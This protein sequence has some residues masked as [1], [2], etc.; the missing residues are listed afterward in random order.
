MTPTQAGVLFIWTLGTNVSEILTK[1]H[2]FSFKKMHLKMSSANW[3]QFYLGLN[4]LKVWGFCLVYFLRGLWLWEDCHR[5]GKLYH[6]NSICKKPIYSY[7]VNL[8]FND[9]LFNPNTS[10]TCLTAWC[11]A[12]SMTIYWTPL[13]SVQAQVKL[14]LSLTLYGDGSI[15][16]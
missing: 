13:S 8:I 6:W 15:L 5:W 2:T 12:Y 11:N 10:L 7:T 4:V 16:V 1:I 9:L 14:K 3:G